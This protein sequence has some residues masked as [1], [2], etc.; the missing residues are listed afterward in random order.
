MNVETIYCD[1][2]SLTFTEYE[3][4]IAECCPYCGND[5]EETLKGLCDDGE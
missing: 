2:C 4:E 1:V 5:E 3:Y